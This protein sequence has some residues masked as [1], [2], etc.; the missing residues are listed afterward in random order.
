L[1]ISS[2]KS[3]DIEGPSEESLGGRLEKVE[4]ALE[5]QAEESK[6][7]FRVYWKDSLRFETADK[8]FKLR[9][10]GRSH[11]DWV[12]IDQ[13]EDMRFLFDTEDGTE[14][15]RARLY[16]S[17]E[18]YEDIIFKFQYDFADG[19]ADFK[20]VYVGMKN[21]PVL[22]AVKIGQFKEPFSLE[23][24]TSSNDI[25]FMERALPNVFAPSRNTGV[26]AQNTAFDDRLNWA[27][28]VFR[29]V[30]DY[31]D[32][33]ADGG[34]NV[35]ARLTGL[36]WHQ[37]DGKKLLHLGVGYSLRNPD[38]NWRYRQRPETHLSPRYVDTG[39]FYADD[40]DLWNAEAAF[41]YGPFSLQGEYMASEVDYGLGGD[42][43][44]DGYYVQASYVL[45]GEHRPYDTASAAFM[46]PKV[47]N[48]L[49]LTNGERGWGAWEAAVRYS[50]IDLDDGN[51]FR[52]GEE[53]NITLGL[54]WYLNN[55]TRVMF[56][57]IQSDIEHDLYDGDVDTFQ[58][59]FQFKF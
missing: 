44:Y 30:D 10:G 57:Y 41:V 43:D 19:D 48:R 27:I 31:G 18:V 21:L 11:N 4:Q 6:D 45:T 3:R 5:D 46:S 16:L 28:G 9:M 7:D 56:N 35:T 2:N 40:I 17:G 38:A 58:T 26:M 42:A 20:D 47:K 32:G 29:D 8:Q 34:Y 33:A 14:F 39:A 54:N 1:Q 24:L 13:G 55:C 52:G 49:S 36:T 12:W 25:T 51:F 50:A 23:E 53:D 22:G 37:D 59:R 15:R